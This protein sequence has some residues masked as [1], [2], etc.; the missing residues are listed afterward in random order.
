MIAIVTNID[1]DHLATYDGD[2]EKLRQAFVEF[3]HNLP[4]YGLVVLCIDDPVAASIAPLLTRSIVPYGTHADADIRATNLRRDGLITRFDVHRAGYDVLPIELNL[5]GRHNVLNALAAVA[6]ARELD[7]ADDAVQEALHQFAG[8]GRRFQV[9]GEVPAGSGSALLVDDYGHHPTEV[10]ATIAA[11][12]E[13]WP[14]RRLVVVFQPHRYT[15]TRDL[16]DDFV[17]VLS[18]VDVLILTE[19]YAAGEA[20]ITGADGRALARAI[21]GR[22]QVE[23]VFV[24]QHANLPIVLQGL[25]R[26]GDLVLMLGA[27]N[28]GALALEM[29][30]QLEK[31]RSEAR[32]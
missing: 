18:D 6:V 16:L 28:V 30:G 12:R 5:P 24:A 21:R 15:R 11:A 10:A 20:P 13:G 7:I 26:N 19:V 14:E 27:G 9:L 17:R 4:F 31:L 32:S 23:P 1:A 22:G 25:L 3:T 2:F 8:I 29:P